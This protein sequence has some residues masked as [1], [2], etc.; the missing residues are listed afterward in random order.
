M[1]ARACA[2][3]WNEDCYRV[4]RWAVVGYKTE[5]KATLKAFSPV[6]RGWEI[7]ATAGSIIIG[8]AGEERGQEAGRSIGQLVIPG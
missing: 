6:C 8:S 1:S 3:N 7:P 4:V 5:T 2:S